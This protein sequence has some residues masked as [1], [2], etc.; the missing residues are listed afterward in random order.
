MRQAL[1]VWIIEIKN[2]LQLSVMLQKH[3][4]NML[5]PQIANNLQQVVKGAELSPPPLTGWAEDQN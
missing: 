3:R 4:V 2:H 5:S 1:L